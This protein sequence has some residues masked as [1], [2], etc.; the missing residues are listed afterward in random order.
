MS[1]LVALLFSITIMI[2][3]YLVVVP[4]FDSANRAKMQFIDKTKMSLA[5]MYLFIDA[6]KIFILSLALIFLVSLILFVATRSFVFTAMAASLLSFA[7]TLLLRVLKSRRKEAFVNQLP[8]FLLSVSTTMAVGMGLTQSIEV[9]AREEGGP[10]QQEFD[11]F[12]NELR[13]G[14]NFDDSLDN[15]NL[16]MDTQELQLVVAA[17]KISREVGGNLSDVLRRLSDTIRTKLE[18]EGKVK[19]LTAQGRMQGIVMVCLPIFVGIALFFMESTKLYMGQ[20]FTEWYGWLTIA[21]LVV[22]LSLG[23]FFIHKIVNIDV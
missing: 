8:D 21:F 12:L 7:P 13:L 23:Y 19:T 18:M 2:L 20:L 15:L 16:R 3:M 1:F 5:D 14:V 6:E 22:M 11:L 4:L 17:M 9:S 10:L